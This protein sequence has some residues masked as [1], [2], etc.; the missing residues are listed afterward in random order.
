MVTKSGNF[1]GRLNNFLM[2]RTLSL[3]KVV[4]LGGMGLCALRFIS[5][6]FKVLVG[7]RL[8]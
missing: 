4:G 8:R 2:S 5:S 7:A 3:V 6:P 1:S